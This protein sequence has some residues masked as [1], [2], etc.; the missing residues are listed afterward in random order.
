MFLS[1][2]EI[3]AKRYDTRRALSSP[4]IL[5]AAVESCFPAKDDKDRKLWRLDCLQGCLYLLI[6]S[7]EKPDFSQFSRQFC[8]EGITGDTKDYLLLLAMVDSGLRFHFRLR[9]NPVHSVA[10]KKG[11]RGKVYAHVTVEQKRDWLI[12]KAPACG[13][14]SDTEMFDVV[15]TDLMRFWRNGKARPVE[16]SAAV[17]EGELEVT[18][19]DMFVKA[20]TEGVGRAKAYGCGLLTIIPKR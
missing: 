9:A 11:V 14:R 1:R 5:H 13:F 18:D 8:S 12:K 2:I 3:D 19:S 6:L 17:F 7:P 10:E 4:Q 20:L 16:I 15:E